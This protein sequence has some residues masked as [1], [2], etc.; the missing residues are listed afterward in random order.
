MLLK[1]DLEKA[2]DRMECV[3]VEETFRD[4]SLLTGMINSIMG[5]IRRSHCKLIWN[6]E[7]MDSIKFTRGLRQGNPLSPYIF[8]SVLNI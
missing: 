4:H 8:C 6:G 1:I 3:F 7:I 2:Y 5:L